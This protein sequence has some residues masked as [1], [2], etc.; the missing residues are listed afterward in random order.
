MQE[1]M[2]ECARR[3]AEISGVKGMTTIKHVLAK[4]SDGDAAKAAWSYFEPQQTGAVLSR[5]R[6]AFELTM[7]ECER[8][9][10]T[11]EQ[12]DVARI[13]QLAT[14]LQR[15]IKQTMPGDTVR[16]DYVALDAEGLPDVDLEIGW[17]S[18]RQGGYGIG[19]PLAAVEVLDWVKDLA[20]QHLDRKPVRTVARTAT[21]ADRAPEITMFVRHLDWQFRREFGGAGRPA[22]IAAIVNALF[23]PEQPIGARD[24]EVRLRRTPLKRPT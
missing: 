7:K 24:A 1:A 18:L 2:Q 8:P 3:L 20:R 5:V 23:T 13:I 21:G 11:I 10:K 16:H 19:Y 15:A 4:L 22:A 6:T 12:E 17:H 14:E 9:Q